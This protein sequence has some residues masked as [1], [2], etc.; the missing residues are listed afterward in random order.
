MTFEELKAEAKAQ[1][2]NLIKINKKEKLLPCVCGCNRREH[3]SGWSGEEEFIKLVCSKCGIFAKGKTEKEATRNWNKM[4]E[5]R[6][7]TN[8]EEAQ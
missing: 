2:Y 4:I 7:A 5:E 8:G 3:W 1:G 6:R